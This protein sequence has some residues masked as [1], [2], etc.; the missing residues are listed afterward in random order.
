MKSILEKYAH[1]LVRY[2]VDIQPREKL[3]IQ[4]TTLA[5]PLIREVYRETLRAGGTCDVSMSF[6]EQNKIFYEEADE[7]QLKHISP[8][9]QKAIEQYD[10]YIHIRAPFNLKEDSKNNKD[11]SK[12]RQ[13]HT[14][15]LNDTYFSR[16]ANRSLKRSLCQYPTIASAQYAGMSMEDYEKF[17]FNA[18]KLYDEDPK[19]SWLEVRKNQQRIVDLLNSKDTIRFVNKD[20]DIT[21]HTNGRTWINS[22]GQTNMPSGE[23]YTSP[24]ETSVNGKITFDYPAIYMG[25]E[26]ERVS[27]W[28]VD[29]YITKWD[30]VRGK[31]FLDEIF[32]I[33]GTRRF[34]EAAIGTNYN[35]QRITK[36]I[37][38]DEKIGGSIHMAIG[39]SYP[40]AGGQNNSVIHWDMIKDM[41]NGGEIFANGDNI[42]RN[43]QF[44]F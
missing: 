23:V 20:T 4:S 31:E 27:L 30:A 7:N 6:R 1:L 24:I 9:Y 3:F 38:F 34:G 13:Q 17:V 29:G 22:D 15:H 19:A 21:F 28:V 33:E 11:K 16:T 44:I 26:V 36:N 12:Q 39:Q 18:C 2:C 8:L 35:I 32:A 14:K 43:G 40:Q 5:E 37:L 42:Y 25:R 41:K 10:A